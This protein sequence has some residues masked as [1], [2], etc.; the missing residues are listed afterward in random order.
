MVRNRPCPVCGGTDRFYLIDNARSGAD[1]YWRCR[2]CDYTQPHDGDE[3]EQDSAWL[4]DAPATVRPVRDAAEIAQAHSAYTAVAR[5]CAVALWTRDGARA[6]EHLRARG[7]EDATIRAA[8]LGWCGNGER[9]FVDLFYNARPAY[10]GAMTGGLRKRQGIPFPVLS[11]TITIPYMDGETCVLLRGR[12][13]YPRPG[14][15]KYYSPKGPLYA[16]DRPRFYGHALLDGAASVILTE[17]ELKALAAQQEWGAGRMSLPTVA[18]SGISYLPAALI[19]AL[20]GKTVYLAYDSEAPKK[21]QRQ[22]PAEQYIQRNGAKL[23]RAGVA[24]K[25][26]T[27]PRPAGVA[28]VDLDSYLVAAKAAA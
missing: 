9:L 11:G 10:D 19:E 1:P 17:G 14:D 27:L 18:T 13:L 22:S 24:V 23:Q 2:Q 4:E 26:I 3:D 15:S 25:V 12:K 5:H 28:K 6:L 16:G 8:G 7:L 21:G 20:V